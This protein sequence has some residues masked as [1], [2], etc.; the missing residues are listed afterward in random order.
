V[1]GRAS[2]FAN[3][4]VARLLAGTVLTALGKAGF[5]VTVSVYAFGYGGAS[6]LGVVLLVQTLPALVAAPL[7]GVA[8]D[9]MPRQR[10]IVAANSARGAAIAV[11]AVCAALDVPLAVF[12]AAVVYSVVSTANQ[13]ARSAL[14][15]VLSRSPAELSRATAMLGTIDSGAVLFGAGLGGLVLAATSTTAVAAGCAVSFG[16]GAL[17]MTGIPTDHRPP[18]RRHTH[19]LREVTGGFSTVFGDRGLRV[20]VLVVLALFVVEGLASVLIVVTA[21]DRLGLGT[22]GV[23]YLNM[24]FGAGG[25]VGGAT[26]FSIVGR[27]R[28]TTA[29]LA[30]SLVLGL[31]LIV[32]GAV[33]VPAVAVIAWL[34][35]GAGYSLARISS[36]TL[37]QRLTPDRFLGRVLSVQESTWVLGTGAGAILAPLL[38]HTLG[39]GPALIV[40]GALVPV[41][42]GL[43]WRTLRTLESGAPVPQ[44]EFAL[45]RHNPIFQPLPVA[46]LEELARRVSTREVAAG[47]DVVRQGDV[48][49]V[50]YFVLSG[51]LQVL[52]D[53]RFKRRLEAGDSFGEIA[54]LRGVP[55]TATVRA[56]SDCQLRALDRDTFL[57]TVTGQADS[58][59]AAVETAA[60]YAP[61]PV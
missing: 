37:L 47:E 21:V 28:L 12:A 1:T 58:H 18:V 55:R 43:R 3:P 50:F 51:D 14:L 19:P 31:P 4:A 20:V 5:A 26:A 23:G 13:P 54:L 10:V 42:L 36:T 56:V 9:R 60:R 34:G 40:A 41:V 22:E 11:A 49:D 53:G 8:S 38:I 45:L 6:A 44:A 35:L 27:S 48:G 52:E 46:A 30:G 25:V 57:L 33:E 29:M 2:A 39:E 32:A 7:L 15:P 16:L 61:A 17:V 24:A 59:D